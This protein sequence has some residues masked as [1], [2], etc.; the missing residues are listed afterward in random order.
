MK[1]AYPARIPKLQPI[2]FF[3]STRNPNQNQRDSS[4]RILLKRYLCR[5]GNRLSYISERCSFIGRIVI[6][7]QQTLSRISAS[8]SFIKKKLPCRLLS[9]ISLFF[10]GIAHF[11]RP[12]F[13]FMSSIVTWRPSSITF[14]SASR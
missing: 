9:F 14:S 8:A 13:F 2:R 4:N 12:P 10:G 11:C 1:K 6:L 5:T 3:P 7:D